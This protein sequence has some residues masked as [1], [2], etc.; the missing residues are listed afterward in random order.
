MPYE[1][2]AQVFKAAD[3]TRHMLIVTSN[4]Y[5]DRE[6]QT[7]TTAALTDYVERQWSG[8]EFAGDNVLL[9][10]L[11]PDHSKTDPQIAREQKPDS[12]SSC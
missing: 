2:K 11:L 7:I 9:F 3:G 8:D 1:N 12:Q 6:D 5:K 4:S 10:E